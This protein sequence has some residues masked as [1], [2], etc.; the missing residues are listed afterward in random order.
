MNQIDKQ[1]STYVKAPHFIDDPHRKAACSA[2]PTAALDDMQDC[3]E[4]LK[5]R[6]KAARCH[7]AQHVLRQYN[8]RLSAVMSRSMS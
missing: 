4:R 7:A 3:V 2:M 8:T 6:V 5:V 1:T